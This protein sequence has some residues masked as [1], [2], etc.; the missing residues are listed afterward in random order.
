MSALCP[1]C[2]PWASTTDLQWQKRQDNI[3]RYPNVG[4]NKCLECKSTD[5]A[6]TRECIAPVDMRG[7]GNPPPIK[8]GGGNVYAMAALGIGGTVILLIVIMAFA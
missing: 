4:F 1:T 7:P 2:R 6:T 3:A 5:W 8:I